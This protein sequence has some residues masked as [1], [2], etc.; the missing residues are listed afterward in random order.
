MKQILVY[1]DS[2]SWGI[3]PDTRNRQPFDKRWPGVMETA[4]RQA[5]EDVRVL[6]NCLN[7][8]RTVW[9]DP[10]KAGRNGS[11]GL[12]QVIEMH[13]PLSLV[14]LMLGTNDFQVTHDNN[15]YLSAQ[16]MG[17]LI[18]II[19]K[20]PIEPGMPIPEIMLV[21]PPVII[22]PRGVLAPKFVGAA[23]R[24]QGL[25]EELKMIADGLSTYFFDV[26]Q[27]VEASKA[28]GIHLDQ[29]QHLGLGLAIAQKVK[30]IFKSQ[31]KMTR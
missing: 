30:K 5:G 21:S 20:A 7:G 31:L 2:L 24:C 6:E 9:S 23:K 8:R 3:V 29:E 16:G 12:A 18:G 28:D 26:N 14:I 27:V 22:K 25:T 19:R 11:Q 1:G 10:F 15:A 13:S 4:L 17:K